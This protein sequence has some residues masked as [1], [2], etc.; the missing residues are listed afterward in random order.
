MRERKERYPR[1]GV[2]A[3]ILDNEEN[4]LLLLRKNPPEAGCW[5][6]PGGSVEHM[7]K[8][9]DAIKREVEEEI[10]VE[11]EI[12]SLL[13]ITEPIVSK[14]KTH[15]VSPVYLARIK[16]GRPKNSEPEINQELRWFSLN[17]LPED[18]NI[19]TRSA[20]N[21]YLKLKKTS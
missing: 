13:T 19:T 16:A 17:N 11:I 18:I 20:I 1:V 9:E 2:A 5:T 15:W 10:G 6:I 8:L 7:E 3:L 12:E 21:S 14:M 4:V